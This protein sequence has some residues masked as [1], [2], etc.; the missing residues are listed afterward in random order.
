MKATNTIMKPRSAEDRE[1]WDLC[2]V[3][4]FATF[5]QLFL[6]GPVNSMDSVLACMIHRGSYT[7]DHVLLN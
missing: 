2:N 7:S 4:T 5:W 6:R 1:F 3:E